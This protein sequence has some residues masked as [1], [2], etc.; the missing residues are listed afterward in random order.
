MPE[1]LRVL[2]IASQPEAPQ[3]IEQLLVEAEETG[4]LPALQLKFESAS[5]GAGALELLAQG[6]FHAVF[7]TLSTPDDL[8]TLAEIHPAYPDL[9]IIVGVN[10]AEESLALLALTRGALDYWH[11]D[12][13]RIRDMAGI[14]RLVLAA[15]QLKSNQQRLRWL[16]NS[17][18]EVVW[19]A[20]P[21]LRYIEVSDSI[22]RLAGYSVEE[23]LGMS[24]PD[25][26]TPA[27]R[28]VLL[29]ALQTTLLFESGTQRELMLELEHHHKEGQNFWAE[30]LLRVELGPQGQVTGLQGLTRDVSGRHAI[31][32]KLEYV[33]MHDALTGLFN[34]VYLE[35]ELT[36]L[37]FSRLYP[38]TILMADFEGLRGINDE[39]GMGAGDEM[40][41]RVA[42][43]LRTAFRS[44]DMIARTH[45]GDFVVFM[46]RANSRAA[47]R[48]LQRVLNLV[49]A[50]NSGEPEL[51]LNIT[52]DVMTAETGQ[53]LRDLFNAAS[54]QRSS[55][56]VIS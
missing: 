19:R 43:L 8:H 4:R 7:L 32:E 24:L 11:P 31:Q 6:A 39:Y 42:N 55:K 20:Q 17:I 18:S 36:R 13:C 37:E 54:A 45:A 44:E 53:S 22:A 49:E 40:L 28:P 2:L 5:A 3:Q 56:K 46:P 21:D 23:A 52:M 48:A 38:I 14:F 27:A 30:V 35:E 1:H 26:L 9:P 33:S 15:A 29:A 25:F 47:G 50:Y 51:P 34:R 10:A 41:K 16:E 12:A